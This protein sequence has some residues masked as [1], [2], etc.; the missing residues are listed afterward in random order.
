MRRLR[1]P[2]LRKLVS[3]VSLDPSKLIYPIFI[4]E[5]ITTKKEISSMPSQYRLPLGEVVKEVGECLDMGLGGV[6]LFGIPSQKDEFGSSAWRKDGVIQKAIH[7][8]RKE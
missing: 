6:I 8:I 7:T 2:K 4:D 1:T 5:N 3:E